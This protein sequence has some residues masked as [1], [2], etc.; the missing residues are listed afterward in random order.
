MWEFPNVRVGGDP[1]VQLVS[2]LRAAYSLKVR[3]KRSI[4][5]LAIVEH[6]YSHFKVTVHAFR[7]EL[8]GSSINGNLKWVR[9][10]ELEDYPMGRID[11]N[12]SQI[13]MAVES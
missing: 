1:T 6:A 10:K 5:P 13:L 2:A 12:V 3:V 8:S 4:H 7:C 9:L 11:R